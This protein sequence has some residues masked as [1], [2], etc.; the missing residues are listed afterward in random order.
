MKYL[1]RGISH[2]QG[3][4]YT[5]TVRDDIVDEGMDFRQIHVRILSRAHQVEVYLNDRWVFSMDMTGLPVAGG[6]G[7]LAESGVLT[8]TKSEVYALE[9]L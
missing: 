2:F 4:T 5:H 9:H 6:F 7:F 3:N 8:V 1:E